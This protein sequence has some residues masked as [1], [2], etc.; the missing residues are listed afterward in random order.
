L[1]YAAG[2]RNGDLRTTVSA[3]HKP[4]GVRCGLAAVPVP[5]AAMGEV[6]DH[7]PFWDR[8]ASKWGRLPWGLSWRRDVALPV[9]VGVLQIAGGVGSAWHHQHHQVD[10]GAI[11]WVLL[12]VG[13]LALVARRRHPVAVLWV[14]FAATL[15]SSGQWAGYLSLIV[16]FFT[17]AT[18]GHRRAAWSVVVVGYVCSNWLGPLVYGQ[19]VAS[20]DQ[21]LLLAAWLLVLVVVAEIRRMY[22]ENLAKARAA[23]E[24]EGQRRAGE[25]R[26]RIARD[27][28]DMIGHNISL[29]NVQ[30][31]VGLDLM[32]THPEQARASLTAI[33]TVSKE[34]RTMLMALRQAGEDVPRSPAPG[35]ERLPELLDL[36][37]AAGLSVTEE[38]TGERRPLPSAVDV[39]AYR[40]VQESLTNVARHAGPATALVRLSYEPD[41]L[42]VEVR[43]NGRATAGN[44]KS[45]AGSGSGIAGMRERAAILGGQLEAGPRPGGGFA[46]KADLPLS[47]PMPL[48]PLGDRS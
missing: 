32:D 20:L 43:D 35:L 24:L 8:F 33:K 7:Q 27:L 26:L 2:R 13:P 38:V 42:C 10:V 19:P 5:W 34:A 41:H 17:A 4:S 36:T 18:G 37:R 11:N 39:A 45:A 47:T 3:A 12:M 6:V 14:T 44:G 31:G 25:E 16:A 46:V 23:R 48:G 9:V 40:I 22:L 28:H 21:A 29:I 1:A 15:G 30:A